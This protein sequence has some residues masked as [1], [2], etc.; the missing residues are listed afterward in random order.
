MIV[1]AGQT[2]RSSRL[3]TVAGLRSPSPVVRDSQNHLVS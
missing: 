1:Q 3:Q 2:I